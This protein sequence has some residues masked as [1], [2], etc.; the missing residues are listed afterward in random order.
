MTTEY[1]TGIG[2]TVIF[3]PPASMR[4]GRTP[5]FTCEARQTGLQ[6]RTKMGGAMTVHG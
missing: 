3:P 5:E 4:V 2:V 1:F 6:Q